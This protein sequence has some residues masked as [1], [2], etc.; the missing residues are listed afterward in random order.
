MSFAARLAGGPIVGLSG[1][2]D[3][4][5]SRLQSASKRFLE[6]GEMRETLQIRHAFRS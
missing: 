6:V 5:R 1:C 4:I 2:T 3:L